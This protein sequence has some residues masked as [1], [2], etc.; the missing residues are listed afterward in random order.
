MNQ[1]NTAQRLL[2]SLGGMGQL[3]SSGWYADRTTPAKPR[4][5]KDKTYY[6]ATLMAFFDQKRKDAKTVVPN[7]PKVA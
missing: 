5:K 7:L 3:M 4:R 2:L 6:G 1:L